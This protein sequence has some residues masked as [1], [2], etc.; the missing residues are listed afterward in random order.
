MT[1]AA[2]SLCYAPHSYLYLKPLEET[3]GLRTSMLWHCDS[4]T[5]ADFSRYPQGKNK[6]SHCST[7]TR[8]SQTTMKSSNHNRP[9]DRKVLWKL[10]QEITRDTESS[11][12]KPT[13]T[14]RGGHTCFYACLTEVAM[15]FPK[16]KALG[17]S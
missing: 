14:Q 2:R 3:R 13:W 16:Q 12:Q 17:R 9:S 1:S 11:Q 4:E 15:S 6:A 8:L 5:N 10:S 7:E